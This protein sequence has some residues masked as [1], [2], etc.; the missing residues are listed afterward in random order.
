MRL[1]NENGNLKKVNGKQKCSNQMTYEGTAK[2][3]NNIPNLEKK[4]N[5]YKI[6]SKEPGE[7]NQII[8]KG[9]VNRLNNSSF[10]L[11]NLK[12]DN[13]S[14]E[15]EPDYEEFKDEKDV[16]KWADGLYKKWYEN[17]KQMQNKFY[18][19]KHFEF[20]GSTFLNLDLTAVSIYKGS[21]YENMNSVLRGVKN[22]NNESE[23]KWLCLKLIFEMLLAPRLDKDIVVYRF[24]NE[25]TFK[26]IKN[27]INKGNAYVEKGFLSTTLLKDKINKKHEPY[28]NH[29]YILKI[30]V[31]KGNVAVY[32]SIFEENTDGKSEYEMI[33]LNNGILTKNNDYSNS[34]NILE[35]FYDNNIK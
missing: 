13:N 3:A 9:T 31:E 6:G 15:K 26:L 16:K 11:P 21:G 29:N 1:K 19:E 25:T 4:N 28:N 5:R 7:S 20:T 30:Y 12:N 23:Y 32:S 24:V 10:K 2:S 27:E 35:L 22:I 8:S 34:E 17:L 18:T 14:N 33:L